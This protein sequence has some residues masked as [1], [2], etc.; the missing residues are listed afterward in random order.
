MKHN[1]CFHG[2][3][4]LLE[5]KKIATWYEKPCDRPW[6]VY[7]G[8]PENR[9]PLKLGEC[10]RKIFLEDVF[11][12]FLRKNR[13]QR[14]QEVERMFQPKGIAPIQRQSC[15]QVCDTFG[16]LQVVHNGKRER[17]LAKTCW[18][19]QGALWKLQIVNL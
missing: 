4:I 2:S 6:V 14:R 19:G 13:I 8:S 7:Y 15:V 12:I 16:K 17:E 10:I 9:H 3:Y 18:S 11:S 5:I 1:V